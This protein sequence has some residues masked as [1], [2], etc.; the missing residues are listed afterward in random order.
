MVY[1]CIQKTQRNISIS[2]ISGDL[3]NR[4]QYS[5]FFWLCFG[6]NQRRRKIS[7]SSVARCSDVF[8]SKR[9]TLSVSR[10][11]LAGQC[12]ALSF[13]TENSWFM[14]AVRL[15]Q[16]STVAGCWKSAQCSA[17]LGSWRIIIRG[18]AH[19]TQFILSDAMILQKIQIS[20]ALKQHIFIVTFSKLNTLAKV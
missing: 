9:L 6:F 3:V 5:L 12:T 13:F 15:N 19:C 1:L 4:S 10:L 11:V 18:F 20:A 7:G 17:K 16:H 2:R 14:R 8:I